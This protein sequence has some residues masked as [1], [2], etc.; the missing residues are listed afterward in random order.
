MGKQANTNHL[1]SDINLKFEADTNLITGL[2]HNT[3]CMMNFKVR[4]L[5]SAEQVEVVT[6]FRDSQEDLLNPCHIMSKSLYL[7]SLS[8]VILDEHVMSLE[9][10]SLF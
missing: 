3:L 6:F 5:I 1:P 9:L 10:K 7:I 2:S 4:R 8:R